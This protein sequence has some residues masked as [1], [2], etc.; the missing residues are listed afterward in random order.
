MEMA[1]VEHVIEGNIITNTTRGEIFRSGESLSQL[2]GYD[3][4]FDFQILAGEPFYFFR[5]GEQIGLNYAGEEVLLG[6]DEVAR[7]YCCGFGIYNP[8]HY[9]NMTAFFASREGERYYV[10]AGVFE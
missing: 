5:K 9:E 8:R 2:F 4:T 7:H 1:H 3:E 6:F 10:E